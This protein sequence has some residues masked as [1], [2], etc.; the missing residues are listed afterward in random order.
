MLMK[1]PT[2]EGPTSPKGRPAYDQECREVLRPHL[3]ALI[4]LATKAGWDR[5]TAA[6]TLMYLAATAPKQAATA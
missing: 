2:I 1:E 3:E 4:E 6:Y 5:T